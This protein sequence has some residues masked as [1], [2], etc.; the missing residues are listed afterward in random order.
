MRVLYHPKNKRKFFYTEWETISSNES[1]TLPLTNLGG[2]T[3]NFIV[4]WG[5]GTHSVVTSYNDARRIH[6][7]TDAGI[8]T[9]KITGQCEGWRFG[10]SGDKLKFR[11]I[12]GG[13]G[14]VWKYLESAFAGCANLTTANIEKWDISLVSSLHG[15]FT[16]CP[17]LSVLNIGKWNTSNVTST[18][19]MCTGC[20]SLTSID[21]SQWDVSSCV[22]FGQYF[23]NSYNNGMLYGCSNLTSVGDLSGWRFSTS[24]D[25]YFQGTFAYCSKV[26]TIGDVSSWNTSKF[27]S[28]TGAFAGMSSL[29][30][31]DVFTWDVSN[32]IYYYGTYSGCSS[33]T[34]LD[35][36]N[37][38][39]PAITDVYIDYL[40]SYCI[41]LESID[42]TVFNPCYIAGCSATFYHCE[43]ITSVDVSDWNISHS[44]SLSSI[45]E[46]CY[47]LT[48]FDVSSWDTSA[49]T[50]INRMCLNC[51]NLETF[52]MTDWDVSNIVYFGKYVWNSTNNAPFW[53]CVK[54]TSV[55]D[56]S[57]WR[58]STT[59]DV[60]FQATFYSCSALSTIGDTS[61]WNTGKLVWAQ[62]SFNGCSS[63][64]SLNVSNWDMSGVI[65]MGGMFANCISLS[66]P[67]VSG[68]NT[69]SNISLNRTFYGINW[70]PDV[71][72]WD[73]SKVTDMTSTFELSSADPDVS[74]WDTGEVLT[75]ERMFGSNTSANPDTSGWDTSKVTNMRYMH[76]NNTSLVRSVL[77][78]V[79][80]DNL[81]V[82]D[83]LHCFKSAVNVS[84]YASIPNNWKGL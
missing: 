10:N 71:S 20:T 1:I 51:V 8:Y 76:Y 31:L 41:N 79:Y 78:S 21:L 56:L 73:T 36:S 5:D 13:D 23:Y 52:D 9:V 32:C 50:D 48:G 67:D 29:N 47:L 63:L 77:S 2:P 42:V 27:K 38:L 7:Y 69:G 34:E 14:F 16:L 3:Y 74:G 28:L 58:F 44:P 54:L 60:Y 81:S 82:I 40:F 75:M 64:L 25:V 15:T 46:G 45:V 53:G 12:W 11:K 70:T 19:R 80:W 49:V 39:P 61:G 35:I 57:G 65:Y 37:W 17:S 68:W 66:T 22:D 30:S 6:T 62:D 84:N 4:Y 72:T 18:S 55:G 59:Q 83:Y 26:T 24:Q 33:L 43:K